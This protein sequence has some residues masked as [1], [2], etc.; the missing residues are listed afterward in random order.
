MNVPHDARAEANARQRAASD[1]MASCFVTASA[2]SGKTKLLTDRLLRLMLGGAPPERLLCLTFTK[3][4]AA[5]MASRLNERLGKWAVADAATLRAELTDLLGRP[6]GQDETD[7]ARDAFA[8]VLELPG[9]MRIATLHAFA[10]SLLRGFPLE[11]GLA[12]GFAVMEE[13]DAAARMAEA[14]EAE[15]PVSPA[16][17]HLA[18]L[19]DAR[20]MQALLR[21]LRDEEAALEGAIMASGGT[22][23]GL[24]KRLA[25]R[26][27]LAPDADMEALALEA[28]A[29]G[30]DGALSRAAAALLL[31]GNGNDVTRGEEIRAFLTLGPAARLVK[32]AAWMDL[33]LTD[34]GTVRARFATKG[35]GANQA[36][37]QA[38]LATEGERLLD[39]ETRRQA[40][41][42]LDA[43]MAALTLGRPVLGHF[44]AAKRRVGRLDYDDLIASARALLENPGAAWVLY[45]LDGGLDHVLLDE[46]QDSNPEQW[47]IAGALTA[48]FTTGEGSN[49][50][51]RTLFAVGDVKQSIFGF[52]GA[53]ATGLPRAA[54]RFGARA[55][56]AGQ[57]FRR[58]ELN[59]SFRS[60]PPVLALVDAVFA[61]GAARQG[62][63]GEGETLRHNP[64]RAGMA[65]CVEIWPLLA[66]GEAEDAPEW[67]VPETPMGETGPD[68]RLAQVLARRIRHMLDH[69]H[70]PA[71]HEG[72]PGQGRRIRAGDI[73]VLVR[74]RDA[75]LAQLVRALKEL[76]V[77]V[78]G[79]DRMVLVE[80]LAVL[81][82]LATLDAILLPEDDLQLAA[83]L[84]SPIFGLEEE[85]LFALA[86]GR[87]GS[88]HA[89]L[90]ARRGE[91]GRVGAAADLFAALSIRADHLPPHALVAEILSERGGRARLLARLGPDAADP[92][93]E[94]LT[95]ALAHERAHPASLQHFL[96]WLRRAA[97]E[98]KREPENSADRVRVMTVHGA[99]GLQAPI[100]ILPDT[101]SA[102]PARAG[103]RWTGDDLPLWAPRAKGFAATPWTDAQSAEAARE[104]EEANRLLYVALTRAEDRLLVCGWYRKKK[105]AA[106]WHDKVAEG[107]RRLP[108]VEE[109]P[110]DPGAWGAEAAGFVDGPMLRLETPQEGARKAERPANTAADAPPLPAWA[111]S[112]AP[113]V[114][115]VRVATP[116]H[117]EDEEVEGAAAPPHAPGDP[118]GTR[119]RRGNLIHALLQSL[120]ELP[121]PQ[122]EAAA[123][124]YLA[125]PGHGLDVAQ[126]AEI[127]AEALAVLAH[128][129]IAAAF[130]P[131]S[132]AEAPIAGRIG[133][134]LILGV[135]DR[136]LVAPDAVLILDFKTN[137]PPPLEPE[138]APP[139]YLRQM[140][141]YRAVL[142][143]A[144]PG[145]EVR[146][147]LVWTYGA[148]VM[149]LPSALLDTHAPTA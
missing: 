25:A 46:A 60:A 81:D 119:F 117:M 148:R 72:D 19:T 86:H 125:R 133:Q 103:L 138:A 104:A 28:A 93:D 116:S 75:F 94:L 67:E 24:R 76:D 78:G 90:M 85:D 74:K 121:G 14:R 38:T 49:A 40:L 47:G 4:A 63:V 31:S 96:H 135:V 56:A 100:V 114:E 149:P 139:A 146:C 59:V 134:R 16:T 99:K 68:S 9:G 50:A 53:D 130:G 145:R 7:R 22:L 2:G 98:V 57:A 6:P 5:E 112:P 44:A 131:G 106:C 3:A 102:P 89:R 64:D 147:A 37:I 142:R 20:G 27:G 17:G 77:P 33:F 35:C 111:R 129:D 54:T 79:V 41:A 110:F 62:V 83:A 144:Y 82:V 45:K 87:A 34:K 69:E 115:G 137:R 126:Q 88:L 109:V 136:L 12:P 43:T 143:L 132:L 127:L 91:G 118:L 11:A 95:A 8:R 10:Q 51:P 71:R 113:E 120:P 97:T 84:K 140:A 107:F 52:Q 80:Q 32:L 141:A 29:G 92:L 70:L 65:G 23:A 128:P 61:D 39:I 30:D 124:R 21:A 1:P 48:E 108:G 55:E 123:A 13:M 73:L 15:L 101:A 105:A 18:T 122:R 42:L 66:A 36:M 26:L 58:V